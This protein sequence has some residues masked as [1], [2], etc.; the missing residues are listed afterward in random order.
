MAG[1]TPPLE[2]QELEG[3]YPLLPDMAS[4]EYYASI[5]FIKNPHPGKE[6]FTGRA[7]F[8][9]GNKS[10]ESFKTDSSRSYQ[11]SS[12]GS[13]ISRHP[14]PARKLQFPKDSEI[15]LMSRGFAKLSIAAEDKVPKNV[16]QGHDSFDS[17]ADQGDAPATSKYRSQSPGTPSYR[18][19][20]VEHALLL[21]WSRIRVYFMDLENTV[22]ALNGDDYDIPN[23]EFWLVPPQNKGFIVGCFNINQIEPQFFTNLRNM[24][25]QKAIESVKG[26]RRASST[27]LR[28]EH[29]AL[30]TQNEGQPVML[31]PS[32]RAHS[33]T[34]SSE[35][36]SHKGRECLVATT[37]ILV[38]S[39]KWPNTIVELADKQY[40]IPSHELWIL[41]EDILLGDSIFVQV[42]HPLFVANY[43]RHGPLKAI[44]AANG[45]RVPIYRDGTG[46]FSLSLGTPNLKAT[47]CSEEVSSDAGSYS[48]TVTGIPAYSNFGPG[49]VD[50]T[51][52]VER[53]SARIYCK[54]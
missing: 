14:G 23:N 46:L 8:P 9:A 28:S 21:E 41:E 36:E 16:V 42:P 48:N 50:G 27:S 13:A 49:S 22:V 3:A 35:G 11:G 52:S 54:D 37:N 15:S 4:T 5:L 45:Y 44:E 20:N 39:M 53:F 31:T 40:A 25:P 17:L 7:V 38:L 30:D 12:L 34:A 32:P 18:N 51:G 2:A 29:G 6:I 10:T 33:L 24:G 1:V 26:H 19:Y 47:E 43:W